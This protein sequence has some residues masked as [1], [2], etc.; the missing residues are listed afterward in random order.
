MLFCLFLPQTRPRGKAVISDIPIRL[1]PRF[2]GAYKDDDGNVSTTS[3]LTWE[4]QS[5]DGTTVASDEKLFLSEQTV[6]TTTTST[7]SGSQ[8]LYL[9][10]N[11]RSSSHP[12]KRRILENILENNTP[13]PSVLDI[14][15]SRGRSLNREEKKTMKK[16]NNRDAAEDGCNENN[17]LE[18]DRNSEKEREAPLEQHHEGK[19]HKRGRRKSRCR[20]SEDDKWINLLTNMYQD[21]IDVRDTLLRSV[22]RMS[23]FIARSSQVL[24]HDLPI[25]PQDIKRGCNADAI[26]DLMNQGLSSLSCEIPS[27]CHQQQDRRNDE[28]MIYINDTDVKYVYEN[29]RMVNNHVAAASS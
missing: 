4:R 14:Q 1:Q 24:I 29:D 3:S 12:N 27:W 8:K 2:S 6:V 26:T 15:P 28:P 5:R 9:K 17:K 11:R 7:S 16:H 13:P 20:G 23:F 10:T 25:S 22:L 18:L 21:S 19:K